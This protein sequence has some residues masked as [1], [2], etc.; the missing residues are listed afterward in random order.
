VIGVGLP[1]ITCFWIDVHVEGEYRRASSA[2]GFLYSLTTMAV[3]IVVGAAFGA[4][5]WWLWRPTGL[6]NRRERDDGSPVDEMR[7]LRV[8]LRLLMFFTLAGGLIALRN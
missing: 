8:V 1:V 7:V 2:G 4:A 5:V 6:A 3:A